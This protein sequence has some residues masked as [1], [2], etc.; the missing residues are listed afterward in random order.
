VS[1][2]DDKNVRLIT[3]IIL[4]ALIGG[5]LIGFA[6]AALTFFYDFVGAARPGL[7]P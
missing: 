4:A 6:I 5:L 2:D 3:G 1:G 7:R